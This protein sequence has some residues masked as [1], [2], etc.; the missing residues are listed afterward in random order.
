VELL[1][2][3]VLGV[4]EAVPLPLCVPEGVGDEEGVG[5][6]VT[7]AV[8]EPLP[9]LEALTPRVRVGVGA[10]V[11]A[12]LGAGVRVGATEGTFIEGA[13]VGVVATEGSREDKVEAVGAFVPKTD[14]SGDNE[15]AMLREGT[16]GNGEGVAVHI[17]F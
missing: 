2:T 11:P 3:V 7:G 15:G 6:G 10:L 5:E 13:E 12:T 14:G 4:A 9:V 8:F 16:E 17:G 1:E